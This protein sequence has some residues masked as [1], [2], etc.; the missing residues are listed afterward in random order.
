[1]NRL[2][3]GE[4]AK[5]AGVRP[6]TLRYYESIG[7]LP[8]PMRE[9]GRRRYDAGVLQRLAIIQTAQRAGFT[10]AELRLLFDQI[11][12]CAAPESWHA[13]VQRKLA[14]LNALLL[15]VQSMKA[16]LEDID[17]CEG[18]S[19]ADCIYETGQRHAAG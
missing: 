14:E 19:L 10:L 16:L 8:A 12:P 18:A 4:V 5:Q 15:N 9:H 13:L 1:M 6:S 2:S 7:L 11:M 17:H 3:I